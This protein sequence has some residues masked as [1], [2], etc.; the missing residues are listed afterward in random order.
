MYS[1]VNQ[2][3]AATGLR[4]VRPQISHT[5]RHADYCLTVYCEHDADPG[6]IDVELSGPGLEQAVGATFDHAYFV[7]QLRAMADHLEEYT[8]HLR[9]FAEDY[10]EAAWA[11]AG[12]VI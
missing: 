3:S 8:V 4:L 5:P 2:I 10:A 9:Q 7:A 1:H 11:D 12:E 6:C